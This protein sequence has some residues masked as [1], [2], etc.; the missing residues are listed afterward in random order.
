MHRDLP[1][2]LPLPRRYLA[3]ASVCLTL[4]MAVLDAAIANIALPTIAR[5]LHAAPAKAVWVINAYQLATTMLLLP[6]AAMGDRI[7]HA[8]VY[9]A[10]LALFVVGSLLCARTGS[11]DGLIAARVVQGAGAAGIMALNGAMVRAIYPAA[12]LGRAMGFIALVVSTASAFGPS[13]A[14]AILA[15]SDWPWLFAINVPLGLVALLVG[16]RCLPHAPGHGAAPDYPAAGLSAAM[17]GLVVYGSERF[18]RE[19]RLSGLVMLLAGLAC[20]G[21]LIWWER[22]KTNPLFPT[23]L[24]AI[25]IVSLSLMTSIT[26]FAAQSLAL[27]CLPFLLQSVLGRSVVESGLL[28][29]PWPIA[30]GTCAL[31]A[32]R[33]A[34]RW[35]AGLLCGVGLLLL[36]GGLFSLSRLGPHPSD[37]DVVWRMVLCGAGFGTFQTPNNR[38]IVGSAPRARAGAAGGMQ[39]TSRLLGQTAGAVA[40]AVG[41]HRLG[42][43][44]SPLLLKGG[45]VAALVA[46][47]FSVA[48]LRVAAPAGIPGFRPG[49]R[50]EPM[51]E[52]D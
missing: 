7:G 22:G 36:A 33:L 34:D 42:L 50:K 15:V 24:L 32:G 13:L 27:V 20:G 39:A 17:L 5:E 30:A 45:A 51:P 49:F 26:T 10:G 3:L 6:L 25:P 48:R 29:T 14:A 28:M 47:G 23:D 37:L 2:G 35:P 4:A 16:W 1:D 19:G 18:A 44:A 9:L 52:A 12:A 31:I 11:L 8:R 43:A 38:T 40:V 41:F 21:A 46:A